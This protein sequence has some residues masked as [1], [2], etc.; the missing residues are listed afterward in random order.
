[1]KGNYG[2][3]K[4]KKYFICIQCGNRFFNKT[5]QKIRK[6]CGLKCYWQS[7]IAKE[8]RRRNGLK[9]K[10]RKVTWKD[11]IGEEKRGKERPDMQGENN[12]NWKGGKDR[13]NRKW[14]MSLF[15][16]R[17][18]RRGV[19]ERDNYCCRICGD[20]NGEGRTIELVVHHIDYWEECPDKRYDIDNGLTV[21]K[22]CHIIGH[23]IF[24]Y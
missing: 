2:R 24:G 14:L 12:W 8:T 22:G 20:R 5:Y 16:Y 15:P 21:C 1:M 17:K 4:T 3:K 10:G 18:W 9:C 6:Y 11:K 23:Q 19:F 7:D 13:N